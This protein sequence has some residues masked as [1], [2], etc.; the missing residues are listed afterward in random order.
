M[1]FFARSTPFSNEE[2]EELIDDRVRIVRNNSNVT[3]FPT[4]GELKCMRGELNHEIRVDE[5]AIESTD[6]LSLG[7]QGLFKSTYVSFESPASRHP[8][9]FFYVWGIT[10]RDQRWM[11]ARIEM[12]GESGYKDRG[13]NRATKV[14]I[15]YT[16]LEQIIDLA[17][18]SYEDIWTHLGYVILE[19]RENARSRLTGLEEVGLAIEAQISALKSVKD[20]CQ[21]TLIHW[22]CDRCKTKGFVSRHVSATIFYPEMS[23]QTA[24]DNYDRL[25]ILN[26][27]HH[28]PCRAKPVWTSYENLGPEVGKKTLQYTEAPLATFTKDGY[29]ESL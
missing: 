10:R 3:T 20:N 17:R 27:S 19:W 23:A 26:T 13:Y 29:T 1:H 7:T 8:N 6:D 28:T 18:T 12:R 4:L 2:W 25:N 11:L 5:P 16:T 22:H 14:Y 21:P 15:Q 24:H 9:G